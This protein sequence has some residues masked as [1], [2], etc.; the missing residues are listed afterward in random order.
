MK[1]IKR[2][3]V[4]PILLVL[5]LLKIVINLLIKAEC[6]VAGVGFLLLAIFAILAIFNKMWLQLGIFASLFVAGVVIMLMSVHILF[7]IDKLK[8]KIE[9]CRDM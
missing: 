3:L 1:R 7:W 9:N 5:E 6:W 8:G 4:V 2:V